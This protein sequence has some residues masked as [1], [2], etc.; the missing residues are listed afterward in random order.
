MSYS[1]LYA[2]WGGMYL[3]C[4]GLGFIEET[5]DLGYALLVLVGMLFFVPPGYIVYKA[6]KENNKD[7]LTTVR[8]LCLL[9]LG[10]TLSGLMA[11]IV[12]ALGS[13][14]PISRSSADRVMSGSGFFSGSNGVP[15]SVIRKVISRLS[16][17]N[18]IP[19]VISPSPSP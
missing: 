11:A 12:S 6:V 19:S 13:D 9:S 14:T 16:A 3:L 4:A 15:L 5:S 8:N 2:L 7:V 10:L 1:L 18:P 17:S